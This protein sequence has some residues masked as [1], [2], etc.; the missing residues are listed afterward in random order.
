MTWKYERGLRPRSPSAYIGCRPLFRTF[1]QSGPRPL[2]WS[3][4]PNSHAGRPS[5]KVG[6]TPMAAR[7]CDRLTLPDEQAEPD[8]RAMPRRSKAISAVSALRPGMAKAK[9][10]GNRS[11]RSRDDNRLRRD[12]QKRALGLV[13]QLPKPPRP[14]HS[15]RR[16]RQ[17]SRL[18]ESGNGR[19]ILGAGAITALLSA[20]PDQPVGDLELVGGKNNA[21]PRPSGRRTCGRTGSA[22]RRRARPCR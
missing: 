15:S 16:S 7:T 4:T 17:R 1:P 12:A 14:P 13:P 8:D 10:F 6:S 22:H 20:A 2:S 3:S 18:A 5:A 19:D 11:E 9:V 21:R